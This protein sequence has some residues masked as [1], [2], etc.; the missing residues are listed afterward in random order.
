MAV[1]EKGV[2]NAFDYPLGL[3]Y[4]LMIGPFLFF[5]IKDILRRKFSSLSILAAVIWALWWF[6]AQ[7]SRFL[8]LPLMIV[9]MVT[10]ARLEKIPRGLYLCLLISLFLEAISLWGAHK[11][12][13]ARWGVDVLR[14][15]DKQM[16]ALNRYYFAHSQSNYIDWPSHDVAYAQFPVTVHKE[17]LPHTILF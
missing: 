6:T 2:N 3:T 13:M 12:D 17:E 7:Q 8:Y 9:F 1:P 10:I 5:L 14:P 4:L 16:L 15:Q 11:N